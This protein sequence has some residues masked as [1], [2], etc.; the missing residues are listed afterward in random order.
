MREFSKEQMKLRLQIFAEGQSYLGSECPWTSIRC[1]PEQL[2]I[3]EHT[4]PLLRDIQP[5]ETRREE[6]PADLNSVY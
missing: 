3:E 2:R 4:R 1:V 5:H 6:Y